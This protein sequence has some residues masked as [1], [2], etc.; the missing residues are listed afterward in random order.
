MKVSVFGLKVI[1]YYKYNYRMECIREANARHKVIVFCKASL[2]L[3]T[4]WPTR[5]AV[6]SVKSINTICVNFVNKFTFHFLLS[7]SRSE[8]DKI[9]KYLNLFINDDLVWKLYVNT[10]SL[11]CSVEGN[12]LFWMVVAHRTSSNPSLSSIPRDH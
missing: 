8:K 11:W 3:Q 12:I 9:E 5:H 6:L 2:D 1:V 10:I 4:V 7:Y